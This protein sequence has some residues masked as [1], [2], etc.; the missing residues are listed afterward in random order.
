MFVLRTHRSPTE[1]WVNLFLMWLTAT[2]SATLGFNIVVSAAE[3][4]DA[5]SLYDGY[6]C[7]QPLLS[8]SHSHNSGVCVRACLQCRRPAAPRS[9]WSA[10][11]RLPQHPSLGRGFKSAAALCWGVRAASFVCGTYTPHL[12]PPG[13][14]HVLSISASFIPRFFLRLCCDTCKCDRRPV[15][16]QHCLGR[17]PLLHQRRGRRQRG[18]FA[19]IPPA[20]LSLISCRCEAM[21]PPGPRVRRCWKASYAM[22]PYSIPPEK[23][24]NK[25][26]LSLSPLSRTTAKVLQSIPQSSQKKRL[27]TNL[28]GHPMNAAPVPALPHQNIRCCG[29]IGVC[30]TKKSNK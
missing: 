25:M 22:L 5:P 19:A 24:G 20:L 16:R 9:S 3:C 28:K 7:G 1:R 14:S 6:V 26:I 10:H 2:T 8:A 12:D 30:T 13:S 21:A 15:S 11:R 17:H 27:S 4:T 29:E 18:G 23:M